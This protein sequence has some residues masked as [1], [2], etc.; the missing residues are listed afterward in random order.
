MRGDFSL[1]CSF[2]SMDQI[3][4]LFGGV[5][6]DFSLIFFIIQMD[7]S[8]KFLGSIIDSIMNTNVYLIYCSMYLHVYMSEIVISFYLISIFF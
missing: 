7:Q 4:Q 5:C 6:A 3:Y 8:C 1:I 2:I